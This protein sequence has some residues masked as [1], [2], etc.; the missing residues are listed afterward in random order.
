MTGSAAQAAET[1]SGG[2][3]NPMW[4]NYR[5]ILQLFVVLVHTWFFPMLTSGPTSAAFWDSVPGRAY[6]G[7]I[8]IAMPVMM[9][10]FCFI[11]GY[12]S[13]S[14]PGRRQLVVQVRLCAAWLINHALAA[15]VQIAMQGGGVPLPFFAVD[16]VDWYLWCLVI[17]RFV[18]PPLALLRRPVA[19][20]L[21][22]AVLML[23]TDTFNNM[24]SFAPWAFAPFFFGGHAAKVRG[25]DLGARKR[26]WQLGAG[27]MLLA[28]F[29]SSFVTDR[30]FMLLLRGYSCLYGGDASFT[31]GMAIWRS[32]T[33]ENFSILTAH[34]PDGSCQ[35]PLGLAH[36][37]A[38]Y[39]ISFAVVLACTSLVPAAPVPLLTTAGR[40]SLY[41]YL[42]QAFFLITPLF[43]GMAGLA[44]RDASL[45]PWA[46]CGMT[47]AG[48]VAYW[49]IFGRPCAKRL[50]G[51]C[52][53]PPVELCCTAP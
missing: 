2:T 43:S 45:G 37:I 22:L 16:S 46:A 24:Y 31:P 32:L 21:A 4:D 53:E 5:G 29:A 8:N 9:P 1:G 44:G 50:F 51:L 36:V 12:F 17:W 13:T 19:T 18:L 33:L 23:W 52:C 25:L 7:L 11:S 48:S 39:A 38:Y 14:T 34:G 10:G 30:A 6:M 3:H 42:T 20:S 35:T 47:L 49:V 27:A 15:G 41:I 28:L 26:S 40:N